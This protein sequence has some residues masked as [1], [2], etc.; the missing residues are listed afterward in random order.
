[1]GLRISTNLASI[2][3]QK[4]MGGTQR[5]L[6]KSFAQLSSGSRITKAADDAAGLSISE[7][8]K[9]TI[10]GY[11]QAQRNANDGISMVQVA[12]GG[13]GEISNILT[14]MRELA[15]QASSDTVGDI[16]RSFVNREVQQLKQEA[17]R[18]AQTTRFGK[19]TM[20]NGEGENFEFQIDI[21]NDDFKDRVG[22]APSEINATTS[23]LGIEGFDFSDKMDARHALEVLEEAQKNVNGHR[24]T[25]GA[26]Q[27]RLVST[28]EN[29]GVAIENFSAA[30]SRIRDTDVAES[31]AELARNNI[32][33]N[34]SVGVLAQA[35]QQPMAALK[36]VS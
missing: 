18:I 35:N 33:L 3:A 29:L 32:L 4:S 21:N 1:M 31:S 26:I 22:F 5:T 7:T 28:T 13:L 9:S 24:A 36:L 20:I 27:N 10:R 12:E 6:Q 16:E 2:N 8:L 34:A 30:N 15:V 25:L 19:T 11:N 17:E 14:R 23:A